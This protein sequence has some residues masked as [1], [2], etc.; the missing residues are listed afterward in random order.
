MGHKAC[1][2]LPFLH[3]LL[4]A[5][6]SLS[7]PCPGQPSPLTHFVTATPVS[8][9]WSDPMLRPLNGSTLRYPHDPHLR[10]ISDHDQIS[11]PQWVP[12]L[13]PYSLNIFPLSTQHIVIATH[14]MATFFSLSSSL[15]YK[16]HR[17]EIFCLVLYC[18][19]L[20]GTL[21]MHSVL[22]KYMLN[23]W[24]P[25][26]LFCMAFLPEEFSHFSFKIYLVVCVLIFLWSVFIL[27]WF[28]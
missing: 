14:F 4:L 19:Q 2:S 23:K 8:P 1:H 21:P 7:L 18:I 20:P 13:P 16:V 27:I 12:P 3:L 10:Q 26:S 9:C 6:L 11:P 5:S 17:T 25:V 15:D 22:N 24:M 28:F